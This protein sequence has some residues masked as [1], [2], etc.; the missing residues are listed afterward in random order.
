MWKACLDGRK[1]GEKDQLSVTIH[2]QLLTK[3]NKF[4]E[5]IHVKTNF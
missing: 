4:I 5:N 2:Q 3:L 1:G